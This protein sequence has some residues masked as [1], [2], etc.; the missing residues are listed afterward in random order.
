MFTI[1]IEPKTHPDCM[2]VDIPDPC[3]TA[4]SFWYMLAIRN[5]L[6]FV[7]CQTNENQTNMS[8]AGHGVNFRLIKQIKWTLVFR[9]HYNGNV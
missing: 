7:T 1:S 4:H 9:Y 8:V 3:E 6:C 2:P 5:F